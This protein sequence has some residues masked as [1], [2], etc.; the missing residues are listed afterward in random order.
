MIRFVLKSRAIVSAWHDSLDGYVKNNPDR[1]IV[2]YLVGLN[3]ITYGFQVATVCSFLIALFVALRLAI[4]L[5]YVYV[6]AALFF[7]NAYYVINVNRA[8]YS[9]PNDYVKVFFFLHDNVYAGVM[10]FVAL[11]LSSMVIV[12]ILASVA[13]LYTI[14]VYIEDE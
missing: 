9:S 10:T 4:P 14:N 1:K 13:V 12:S 7:G 2:T 3:R 8:I 5:I 11:V 6:S